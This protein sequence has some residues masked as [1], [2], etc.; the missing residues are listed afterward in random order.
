MKHIVHVD[1][2]NY[3]TGLELTTLEEGVEVPEEVFTSDMQNCY[4]YQGGKF[5]LDKSK[6]KSLK[7]V[8]ELRIEEEALKPTI[9]DLAEA[10]EILTNIVMEGL[11]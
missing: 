7:E 2:N 4:K 5:T 11:E 10:I 9:E 8:E 1:D 3:I 6:V